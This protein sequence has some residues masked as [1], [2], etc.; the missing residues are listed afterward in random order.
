MTKSL[1]LKELTDFIE[2]AANSTY[3]EVHEAVPEIAEALFKRFLIIDG[4]QK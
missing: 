1:S 2:D 3:P 4:A